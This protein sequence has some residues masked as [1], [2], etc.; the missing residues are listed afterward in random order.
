M[1]RTQGSH[2]KAPPPQKGKTRRNLVVASLFGST[3]SVV[4][5]EQLLIP[6]NALAVPPA[7]GGC[8][9]FS[10]Q[11]TPQ[12][13]QDAFP[14]GGKNTFTQLEQ[15]KIQEVQE[16]LEKVPVPDGY[17]RAYRVEQ[18]DATRTDKLSTGF[19]GNRDV[20]Y[21]PGT[22]VRLNP[23]G[24]NGAVDTFINFG[25]TY[26]AASY[27]VLRNKQ[28]PESVSVLRQFLVPKPW[29]EK[30]RRSAVDEMDKSR[31]PDKAYRVDVKNLEQYGLP[32]QV[33]SDL[34]RNLERSASKQFVEVIP[35]HEGSTHNFDF[36][37]IDD[38]GK[39]RSEGLQRF[40]PQPPVTKEHSKPAVNP[41]NAETDTRVT[42]VPQFCGHG[43]VVGGQALPLLNCG[44]TREQERPLVGGQAGQEKP[45]ET[46]EHVPAASGRPT[47]SRF[48]GLAENMGPLVSHGIEQLLTN[49]D[50][51]RGQA[52]RQRGEFFRA[53]GGTWRYEA[54]KEAN[55]RLAELK[56]EDRTPNKVRE[57]TQGVLQQYRD[58]AEQVHGNKPANPQIP[59]RGDEDKRIDENLAAT[60]EALNKIGSDSAA[61][62]K[63]ELD[64]GDEIKTEYESLMDPI[65]EVSFGDFWRHRAQRMWQRKWDREPN[66]TSERA[67][68]LSGDVYRY[69]ERVA[70][71]IKSDPPEVPWHKGGLWNGPADVRRWADNNLTKVKEELTK[72]QHEQVQKYQQGHPASAVS[73]SQPQSGGGQVDSSDSHIRK[74][75]SVDFE[76]D[77]NQGSQPHQENPSTSRKPS[78]TKTPTQVTEELPAANQQ[79]LG[80]GASGHTQG[81]GTGDV[82]P[83]SLSVPLTSKARS[84]L[85]ALDNGQENQPPIQSQ[86]EAPVP[87]PATPTPDMSS[88]GG[89]PDG[90][91][92]E[93]GKNNPLHQ[94]GAGPSE[95]APAASVATPAP[96]P[97]GAPAASLPKAPAVAPNWDSLRGASHLP[98]GALREIAPAPAPAAAVKQ[99]VQEPAVADETP[100]S[101]SVPAS[102]EAPAPIEVAPVAQQAQSAV[103]QPAPEGSQQPQ[104]PTAATDGQ[105]PQVATLPAAANSSWQ[106]GAQTDWAGIFKSGGGTGDFAS[107]VEEQQSGGDQNSQQAAAPVDNFGVA[108]MGV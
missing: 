106:P 83:V 24:R 78:D 74:S 38:K 69:F 75:R 7:V 100:A 28:F 5:I 47:F 23:V 19:L 104:A 43:S 51:F 14:K 16:K 59:L 2:R 29:Y 97:A 18:K 67:K 91:P 41:K 71:R 90:I 12:Q 61:S 4:G 26:R 53:I 39:D 34:N 11:A 15:R 13:I 27:F 42:T 21:S 77:E 64:L 3:L 37:Y 103:E 32:P 81:E 33:S 62:T 80:L 44:P 96:N 70:D 17:I 6:S 40:Q 87:A 22:G 101:A 93:P 56:P 108:D 79:V 73:K 72:H 20:Q 66:K 35:K 60:Q 65:P 57:I 30:I 45:P 68:S 25:D 36:R 88:Q 63:L 48:P 46:T 107:V 94:V 54:A 52:E 10:C 50:G 9:D 84:G 92:I 49:G 89:G 85:A 8:R 55:R 86:A 82:A 98:G 99:P 31:A 102:A 76:S 95:A 58:L 1:R 105:D